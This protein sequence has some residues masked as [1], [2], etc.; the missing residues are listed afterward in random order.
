MARPLIATDVPGCRELVVEGVTGF[1]CEA[2]SADSLA[3]AMIKLIDLDDAA[4]ARLGMAARELAE[5][6]YNEERVIG[7]YL[8]ALK[9][10]CSTP[11]AS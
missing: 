11:L 2:R 6:E 8:D 9:S 3:A 10:L 5:R 7:A 4:R 1:L